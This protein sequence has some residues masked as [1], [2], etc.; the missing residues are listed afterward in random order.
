MKPKHSILAAVL[1]GII[2]SG[3]WFGWHKSDTEGGE[4]SRSTKAMS[5]GSAIRGDESNGIWAR[6]TRKADLRAYKRVLTDTEAIA[7]MD[8]DARLRLLEEIGKLV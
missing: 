4:A 6:R 1:L 8:Y 7:A 3:Y 2:A 5:S